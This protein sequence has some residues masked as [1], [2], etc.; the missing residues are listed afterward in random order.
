LEKYIEGQ[1]FVIS[2]STQVALTMDCLTEYFFSTQQAARVT[3]DVPRIVCHKPF[4]GAVR[5]PLRLNVT[6]IFNP[7]LMANESDFGVSSA[8]STKEINKSTT[9]RLLMTGDI[10]PRVV[11]SLAAALVAL[12]K[13]HHAEARLPKTMGR[14]LTTADLDPAA[15]AIMLQ[16]APSS[17]VP[18][19]LQPSLSIAAAAA[20]AEAV[21]SGKNAM[22][23]NPFNIIAVRNQQQQQQQQ[24]QGQTNGD[25]AVKVNG[26][27]LSRSKVS[28]EVDTTPTFRIK[29][30]SHDRL[31]DFANVC[32]TPLS[33][34]LNGKR[35]R[36]D[37][38]DVG[39]G[40]GEG[41]KDGL[42]QRCLNR[43][44]E[45]YWHASNMPSQS[46]HAGKR[47]RR[48][49]GSGGDGLAGSDVDSLVE[50]SLALNEPAVT[51]LSSI[52]G[53]ELDKK[54]EIV[55]IGTGKEYDVYAE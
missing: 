6:S 32:L 11:T 54:K 4:A 53:L 19:P 52:E 18:L 36:G 5:V 46:V 2:G 28:P 42:Y 3:A 26:D 8:V 39:D 45:I 7:A 10:L 47:Q 16:S 33:Q 27:A 29:I 37:D 22:V 31:Q 21:T 44:E 17:S 30:F 34:A 35:S 38:Q 49:S 15:L 25:S 43:V 40:G 1:S 51:G 50:F 48:S 23:K 12:G 55:S 9:S 20:A 41:V 13:S 24:Q 14:E